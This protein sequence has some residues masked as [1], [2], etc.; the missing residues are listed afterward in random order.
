MDSSLSMKPSFQQLAIILLSLLMI[1]TLENQKQL[2]KM[3]FSTILH[4]MFSRI[5]LLCPTTLTSSDIKSSSLANREK[6]VSLETALSETILLSKFVI[7]ISYQH[8]L[9][10]I[11]IQR[12]SAKQ[13]QVGSSRVHVE[14]LLLSILFQISKSM[15]VLFKMVSLTQDLF[16]RLMIALHLGLDIA[17]ELISQRQ[18]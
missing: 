2:L 9:I 1:L 12:S 17:T 11:G 15:D 5:D 7:T 13:K 4:L 16:T 3:S 6:M 14:T 18:H 8:L 10:L